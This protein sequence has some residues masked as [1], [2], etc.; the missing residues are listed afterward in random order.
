VKNETL[1]KSASFDRFEAVTLG[2]YMKQLRVGRHLSIRQVAALSGVA[3]STL[4]RWEAG[5]AEAQREPLSLVL[6]VLGASP[7]EA[8]IAHNLLGWPQLTKQ[9]AADNDSVSW[10]GWLPS[11]G[12][13]WRALR[14]RRQMS[15]AD[16]ARS[17]GVSASNVTRLEGGELTPSAEL[18]SR[19]LDLYEADADERQA[20]GGMALWGESDEP[21]T[22][23]DWEDAVDA[24]GDALHDGLL[25]AG[26]LPF[27]AM[28]ARLWHRCVRDGGA[29]AYLLARAYERHAAR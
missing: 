26:D 8:T 11:T 27:L 29:S 20:L 25:I 10:Q 14:E 1:R 16:A 23:A 13:L 28:E 22:L 4:Y 5:T 2:A 24:L 17:V 21:R 15:G 9:K 19:L 7:A 6:G 3:A 18:S 12:D